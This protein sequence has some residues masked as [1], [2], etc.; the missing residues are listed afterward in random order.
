MPVNHTLHS[1]IQHVYSLNAC[2]IFNTSLY[3][4]FLFSTDYNP[5]PTGTHPAFQHVTT[6]YKPDPDASMGDKM[7]VL[8]KGGH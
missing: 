7:P 2:I 8:K 4:S 1:S 5:K 6:T 3:I